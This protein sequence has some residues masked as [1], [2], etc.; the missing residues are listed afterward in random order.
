MLFINQIF[1]FISYFC[2]VH[3]YKK[4][5]EDEIAESQQDGNMDIVSEMAFQNNL[6]TMQ[7]NIERCALQH[8]DF[9]S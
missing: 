5:I 7:N 1:R 4:L 6:R 9:W 8:M 3:R 2:V